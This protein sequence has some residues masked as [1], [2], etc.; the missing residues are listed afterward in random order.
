MARLVDSFVHQW[1][2]VEQFVLI[3]LGFFCMGASL[4][5]E[6]SLLPRMAINVF[7]EVKATTR[8]SFVA[9][10]GLSKALANALVGPMADRWGRKPTLIVGSL[11][12]L[13]VMPYVIVAKTCT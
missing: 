1:M 10:F 6:R 2:Q 13:T 12:G 8:L 3:F 11:V 4:G 5:F 7:H 9:T